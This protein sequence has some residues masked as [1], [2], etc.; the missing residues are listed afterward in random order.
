[1]R[2]GSSNYFLGFLR[3][4]E[5]NIISCLYIIHDFRNLVLLIWFFWFELSKRQNC[6]FLNRIVEQVSY[7]KF[8][9][10]VCNVTILS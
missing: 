9:C 8:I 10:S 1:M 5:I 6:P 4:Y 7:V 2:N 3:C